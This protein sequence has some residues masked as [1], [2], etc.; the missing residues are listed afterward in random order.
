MTSLNKLDFAELLDHTDESIRW[1][2]DVK[3]SIKS[4]DGS[5]QKVGEV[6]ANKL[7]LSLA[8]P[9]FKAQFFG[10][11]LETTE[12]GGRTEIVIEDA[13]WAGFRVSVQR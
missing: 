2:L 13:T 8:S 5:D 9:V 6:W 4:S 7:L 1:Q 10:E 12:A 3:F 11:F